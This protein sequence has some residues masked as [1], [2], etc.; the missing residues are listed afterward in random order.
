MLGLRKDK[1]PKTMLF[2]EHL[3]NEKSNVLMNI[4]HSISIPGCSPTNCLYAGHWNFEEF[5]TD[6]RTKRSYCICTSIFDHIAKE[7]FS[8]PT[9][10]GG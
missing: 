3:S 1:V 4:M 8:F 6:N 10:L 7:Q 5:G 2:L 9:F